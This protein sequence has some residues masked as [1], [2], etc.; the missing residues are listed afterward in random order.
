[1]QYLQRLGPDH[2]DLILEFSKWVLTFDPEDGYSI[3]TSDDYP[4]I[5]ELPQEKV[6]AHLES[7]APKFVVRCVL[8]LRSLLWPAASLHWSS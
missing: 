2:I 7:N 1:M 3:F 5:A 4:E 6:L 8:S